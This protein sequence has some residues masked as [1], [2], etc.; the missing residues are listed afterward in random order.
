MVMMVMGRTL[1]ETNL[2]LCI[3]RISVGYQGAARTSLDLAKESEDLKFK[4]V[5]IRI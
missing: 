1:R 2:E 5:D 4:S 3:D